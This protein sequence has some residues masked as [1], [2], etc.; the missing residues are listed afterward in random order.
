[1]KTVCIS[2]RSRPDKWQRVVNEFPKLK[3]DVTRFDGIP[4]GIGHI[5][6]IKSHQRVHGLMRGQNR[7]M[8]IEDDIKVLGTL[9]DLNKSISQLPKD[10][11]CL[12]LGATLTK[13]LKRYSENLFRLNGGLTTHAIIFNG[14]EI[15]RYIIENAF[16]PDVDWHTQYVDVFMLDVQDKFNCFIT[17]PMICTQASGFSDT[18]EQFCNYDI[19]SNSYNEFTKL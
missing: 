11:D 10:W 6:C 12:Y 9:S 14:P 1:M 3:L 16:K 15:G 5:G 17:D 8:V 19:I 7:Y 13:P 2:L 18:C 4:H